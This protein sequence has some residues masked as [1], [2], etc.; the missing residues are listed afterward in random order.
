V[1]TIMVTTTVWVPTVTFGRLL[2]IVVTMPGTGNCIAIVHMSEGT[3]P[4]SATGLVF[5]V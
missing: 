3:P 1:T 4:I 2:S 5:V